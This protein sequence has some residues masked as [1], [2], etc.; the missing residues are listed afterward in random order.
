MIIEYGKARGFS[1]IDSLH[2]ITPVNGVMSTNAKGVGHLLKEA[3]YIFKEVYRAAF[4][5]AGNGKEYISPRVL[6]PDEITYNLNI[7]PEEW[8]AMS[9]TKRANISA[10]RDRVTTIK[11]G[12]RKSDGKIE[13]E[14]EFSYYLSN[15]IDAGLMTKE[16]YIKYTGDMFLHRAKTGL[17]KVLGL[18]TGSETEELAVVHNIKTDVIE[19]ELTILN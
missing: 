16:T 7:T 2:F 5:Y 4:I 11:Y 1:P 17:S 14:G 12:F 8:S 6:R 3:G 15:A 18:L 10:F 9:E 19:G 13:W